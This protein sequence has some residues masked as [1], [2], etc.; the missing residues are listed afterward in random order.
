MLKGF[1][2]QAFSIAGYREGFKDKKGRGEL[3]FQLE[4]ILKRS[5]KSFF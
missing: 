5:K 1:P 4:R 2:C 3:F